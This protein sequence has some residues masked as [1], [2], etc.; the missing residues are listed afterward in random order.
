[1]KVWLVTGILLAVLANTTWGHY[2]WV[3]LAEDA[4]AVGVAFSEDGELGDITYLDEV[5]LNSIRLVHADGSTRTL[6]LERGDDKIQAP[7]ELTPEPAACLGEVS[8][9]MLTRGDDSF[10]LKYWPKTMRGAPETWVKVDTSQVQRFDLAPRIDGN[11]LIVT[12]TWD[13]APLAN[14]ELKIRG[15]VPSEDTVT[16]ANGQIVIPFTEAGR[17][18]IRVRH[19]ES[20]TGIHDG[21]EYNEVR[22]YA[23]LTI[24][25]ADMN[26]AHHRQWP[27]LPFGLTSFGAAESE[28]FLYV[29]GGHKGRPHHYTADDQSNAFLRLNLNDPSEWEVLPPGPRLQG[30]ALAA[31][32]G[33]IYRMGGFTAV[34]SDGEQENLQ[35]QTSFARF[36]PHQG[37]WEDLP[38]MPVARSSFDATV[39]GDELFVVGG[40]A[41]DGEAHHWLDSAFA[42]NLTAPNRGWRELPKPDFLRRAL[43]VTATQDRIYVVGGMAQE[44]PTTAVSYF[45]TNSQTWHAAPDLP[46]TGRL[47]G[48]GSAACTLHNQVFVTSYDGSLR[49]LNDAGDAWVTCGKLDTSRFFHQM[50]PLS[51][52]SLLVVA[53]A[54]MKSGSYDDL[55]QLAIEP[56]PAAAE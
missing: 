43:A 40:W 22:H 3:F 35:S 42:I 26:V 33:K 53:G 51:S 31:H 7:I 52:D 29:Y 13:G 41:M 34:N 9:G 23:T 16:D 56:D 24:D 18:A 27:A 45:D 15:A 14:A 39:Q 50:L 5:E 55:V 54:N 8:Y 49:T 2:I 48:F 25:R 11:N 21:M 1:M 30:L 28:G 17:Y 44:G 19:V 10:L 20:A 12:A 38:A 6:E 32:G 47:A 4:T 46:D 37:A 36:D